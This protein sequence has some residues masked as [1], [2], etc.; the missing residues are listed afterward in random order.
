MTYQNLDKNFELTIVC[1]QEHSKAIIEELHKFKVNF[2]IS[3]ERGFAPTAPDVAIN[4]FVNIAQWL[5]IIT[6][7]CI[8]LWTKRKAYLDFES[9]HRLAR[10]MLNDL[11][12]LVWIKG[13][14]TPE[15]SY[16]EF[17]TSRCFHCWEMNKGSIRHGPL[18]K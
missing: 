4:V 6:E 11:E 17:K 2:K 18:R 3:E 9:R 13:E 14:D 7:I 1:P 12:P 16:Y 8:V 10:R 15:Y 5:P